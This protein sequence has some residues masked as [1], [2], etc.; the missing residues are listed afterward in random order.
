MPRRDLGLGPPLGGH[1]AGGSEYPEH[2]PGRVAVHRGV[3]EHVSQP[4]V[5]VANRKRIVGQP[6]KPKR[7]SRR[8]LCVYCG[9]RGTNGC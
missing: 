5:P 1:V 8:P 6:Y 9:G 7:Q 3:V 4:A 2:V